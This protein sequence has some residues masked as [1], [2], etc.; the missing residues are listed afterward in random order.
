MKVITLK[1]PDFIKMES[2]EVKE[3]DI[4]IHNS[5]FTNRNGK[6]DIII[7]KFFPQHKGNWGERV[8]GG[9]MRVI[10]I[11]AQESG[12]V[13]RKYEELPDYSMYL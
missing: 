8:Q 5:M 12:E 10:G 3:I 2:I 7:K 13:L 1:A 4:S 9:F 11:I 6:K